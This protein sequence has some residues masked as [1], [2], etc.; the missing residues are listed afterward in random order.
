MDTGS[1]Y[2]HVPSPVDGTH[3]LSL[4]RVL[5]IDHPTALLRLGALACCRLTHV[6][7]S[8]ARLSPC[9]SEAV[10]PTEVDTGLS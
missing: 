6:P 8:A 4:Q 2:P 9:L 7:L 3:C 10:T 1:H 5:I